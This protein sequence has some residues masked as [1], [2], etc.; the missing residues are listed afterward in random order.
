MKKLTILFLISVLFSCG[1]KENQASSNILENLTFSVDT[2]MVD[3]GDEIIDLGQGARYA[4]ISPDAKSFYYYDMK[5]AAINEVDLQTLALAN[6]FQFSKE[7]PNSIGFTPP[8]V[9]PLSNDRFFFAS[10]A[11]VGTYSNAGEE[12]K[13]LKFNFKEIE[14]LDI[15]EGGII[16][17]KAQFSPDEKSLFVLTNPYKTTSDVRLMIIDPES[18]TGKSIPLPNMIPTLKFRVSFQKDGEFMRRGEAVFMKTIN[19]KLFITSSANS[20]IYIY[21][22]QVDSLHFIEFPHQLVP[23]KKTAEVKN[24]V[25]VKK[26]FFAETAKFKYQISF[27]EFLWDE[28][29]QQYLRFGYQLIP[30]YNPKLEK[31]SEVFLFAYDKDLNL[32]GET[33]LDKVQYRFE[34]PFFKDGKLWS[35]VNVDDELGFA[36]MTIDF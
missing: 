27:D 2:V 18:K 17:Y 9:Q 11:N 4:S 22:Y 5:N 33:R 20:N 36:L 28:Q 34:S 15:D 24:K 7:G 13:S 1:E 21:D 32:I 26:E 12:E 31:K 6:T 25:E 19:N 30:H 23:S 8:R 10:S 35:Y 29:R 16:S 14:G 3:L